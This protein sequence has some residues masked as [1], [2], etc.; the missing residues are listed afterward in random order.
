MV[1]FIDAVKSAGKRAFCSLQSAGFNA[2][3]LFSRLAEGDIV[4]AGKFAD[5]SNGLFCNNP[6][7]PVFG[8][9]AQPPFTG[10]Q[11]NTLYRVRFQ[12]THTG[13]INFNT[14]E[15]AETTEQYDSGAPGNLAGPITAIR[16]RVRQTSANCGGVSTYDIDILG[17]GGTLLGG[18]QVP[19]AGPNPPVITN[20]VI[21]RADGLADDCG[22]LPPVVPPY[23]P[24][25]T[26]IIEDITYEPEGGGPQ[27]T[28]PA[29][30]ILG[31]AYVDANANIR[32]PVTVNLGGIKIPLSLNV[33]TGDINLGGIR[34][35]SPDIDNKFDIRVGGPGGTTIPPGTEP[36]IGPPPG[37]PDYPELDEPPEPDI[38][39][40]IIGAVVTT[41][42]IVGRRDL[43]YQGGGNP[44]IEIPRLGFIN[45][46]NYV[47]GL[48][49]AWSE[50][51]P[52]KNLR[53]LV[54][55]PWPYGAV[56]VE[57]SPRNGVTW[58][59]TP[60]YRQAQLPIEYPDLVSI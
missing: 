49:L 31:F 55:N 13:V 41:N 33:T 29:T 60:V 43:L 7:P 3:Y 20:I 4:N 24:G 40:I 56:A 52:I 12:Y 36:P 28:I 25:S 17:A 1:T 51:I 22:S 53:H 48:G 44:N 47:P 38:E 21:T 57:G 11:C 45:F 14:C 50:D 32:I 10:G 46:L 15:T 6:V 30:V 26:T 9:S 2:W 58:T 5:A 27:I 18:P 59:I 42:N 35:G 16:P 23:Q 37:E 54:Q 8:S 19:G 34:V 39:P